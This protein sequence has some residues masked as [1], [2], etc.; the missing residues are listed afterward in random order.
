MKKYELE[1]T[2]DNIRKTIENNILGRNNN[3]VMLGKML[4][5]QNE[6]I[7]ISLDGIWGSGKTFF[8]KQFEYLIKNI[9]EF[10]DNKLF[11][12]NDKEIF[13]KLKDNNLVIYY[14]AWQN[15]DHEEPLESIMYATLNEFPNQK[16]QLISF[17]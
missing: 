14:N 8:I 9:D 16:N 11:V 6:N 13:R 10:P 1:L 15:D 5:N 17:K 4:L 3:L 12:E 2:E 7:M